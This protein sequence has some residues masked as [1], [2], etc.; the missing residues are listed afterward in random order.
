MTVQLRTIVLL[1]ILPVVS[2]CSTYGRMNNSWENYEAPSLANTTEAISVS[3]EL[4]S[5]LPTTADRLPSAIEAGSRVETLV[6]IAQ[7]LGVT[8][9]ALRDTEPGAT[10]VAAA[11]TMLNTPWT[12]ATAEAIAMRRNP[13]LRA[14]DQRLAASIETI[15]QVTALDEIL[16]QY[17]VYTQS[18]MVGVGPMKGADTIRMKFP[19]PGVAALKGQVAVANIRIA[20][21][22]RDTA[23]RNTL[24]AV[25]ESYWKL[26]FTHRAI[27]I[28]RDT[29]DLLNRLEAVA[30]T[31]YK[32]GKTSYQDVAK[33]QI[34]RQILTEDLVTLRQ[35]QRSQEARI[36]ALLNLNPA[37]PVARPARFS[38]PRDLPSASRLTRLAMEK[39]QE[40]RLLRARLDKM[41]RMIGMAETM[42][43]PTF[44][45][46][47]SSYNHRPVQTVGGGAVK[48]PFDSTTT[49][50]RGAGLPKMPW[51][52]SEDAYLRE[53]R[54]KRM[55]LESDLQNAQAQTRFLVADKW[56]ALDQALREEKLY[57]RS[58]VDLSETSLTVSTREY[59]AG[60]IPFAEVIASHTLWLKSH[61]SL[62][63]KRS[64]IGTAR[65][66]LLQVVGAYWF[67]SAS[68]DNRRPSAGKGSEP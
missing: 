31:R 24:S 22:D 53:T 10:L 38:P 67:Q 68:Q 66:N 14:A 25:Q 56:R 18:Q 7:R 49:A 21:E 26:A 27:E 36:R 32:S 19:F 61:L 52:G 65:A 55:A 28:S 16:K 50:Q 20:T 40:L 57:R 6:E 34:Q 59:E 44:G 39:R 9:E 54:Q 17:A 43:Q 11:A 2:G 62:A 64:D 45:P 46:N 60:K 63:L 37:A 41:D 29:L 51:F 8:A 30:T 4:R 47:L 23:Y 5:E 13:A 15:G 33:V 3:R 42:I 48:A 1:M 12:L 35:R 58:L